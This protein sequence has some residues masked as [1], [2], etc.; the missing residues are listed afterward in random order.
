MKQYGDITKLS[1]YELDPVDLIVGESP[2]QDLSVAGK[3]AGL[4]GE[5]S[6]LFMEMIRIIRQM[7][8]KTNGVYPRYALFENVP[9]LF[10]SNDGRDF[11]AVL[12][13]YAR[14][15]DPDAPDVSCPQEG[16]PKSGVL[17]VSN[18]SIAWRTHDAQF[19]GVPQRRKRIALVADFRG[20]TAWEILFEQYGVPGH[21]E[22]SAEA[23]EGITGTP[24]DSTG[25][26]ITVNNQAVFDPS[27]HHEY[28]EFDDVSETVRS[29]YGTGGNNQPLVVA[30]MQGFGDYVETD[31]ASSCKQR[32]YKDATDQV[33]RIQEDQPY[34]RRLTPLECERL[35][36]YPDGWTAIPGASDS[37]RYR[38]LGNSIAIPFWEH[39]A[40]RFAEIGDV[41]TIGSLFA[42]I[43]GFELCFLRAGA[44]TTWN[45]EIDPFCQKVVEYHHERGEL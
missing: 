4:E 39:L 22:Q 11:A 27:V 45:S 35:Q 21:P 1:G 23:Q 12:G 5:R 40:H 15:I 28:R 31:I 7:R 16:W 43:G 2:C 29:R 24:Q 19:W 3:R 38:A 6:G 20:Q 41:K 25:T 13:E 26:K 9:G 32:D 34:V 33:C 44:E 17:L 14:I 18:G 36:G 42:G 10:S 30:T 37:A 8:R